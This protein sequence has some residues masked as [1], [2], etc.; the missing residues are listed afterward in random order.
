VVSGRILPGLAAAALALAVYAGTLGHAFVYDDAFVLRS[1]MLAHPWDLR[2]LLSGGFYSP[3]ERYT[4]LYR[5]L[6]QWSLVLNALVSRQ[7]ALFH[8][9]NVLLHA[10]ATFLLYLWL[11]RLRLPRFVAGATAMLWAVH[12][13]HAEVVANVTARYESL[14]AAFGLA[15]LIA[16][17]SRRRVL[18]ALL[19]LAALMCKETAVAFVPVALVVDALFPIAGKRFDPRSIALP[20]IALAIW[21][22]LR[23]RAIAGDIVPVPYVENPAAAAPSFVRVLTAGKVQLLYLRDQILPLWLSTDHS[24]AQ[25]ELAESALDPAFLGFVAVFALSAAVAWRSRLARPEITLAVAGWT[26]LFAPVA[27]FV[28]P[29]GTIMADRLA[30]L[31]SIFTCLLAAVALS[32]LR[33]RAAA[34]AA[35]AAVVLLSLASFAQA[36]VWKDPLT[37]FAEQVRTAPRSAKAHGN[38]G[39]ALRLAGRPGESIAE[40]EKS[41]AIHAARPEPHAGLAQAYEALDRDPELRI[42]AW[43]DAI[44]YG[45]IGE[46]PVRVRLLALADLGRW[47][48][49]ARIR[50]QVA[51]R[52]PQDPFLARIDRLLLAADLSMK[53]PAPPGGAARAAELFRRGDWGAAEEAYRRALHRGEVPE[54]QIPAAVLDLARCHEELGHPQQ[55]VWYRNLARALP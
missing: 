18:A 11:A 53:V 20:A 35:A 29:I 37:L 22:G 5:P 30:Y 1:P 32:T 26:L 33:P 14:C 36:G 45:T 16:H 27:N 8:A 34:V 38:Y 12:P 2:E 48:E 10:G 44:R 15:F 55:A 43:L 54:E 17:R 39:D 52:D 49:I 42:V 6:A 19:L 25:I 50:E 28:V 31:P 3:Y 7:P 4:G 23:A 41:I 46:R 21:F 51:A 40:Y 9:V 47:P 24:K 13:V